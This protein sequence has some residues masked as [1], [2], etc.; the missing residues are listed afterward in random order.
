MLHRLAAYVHSRRSQP[1]PSSTPSALGRT[2][3]QERARSRDPS[4]EARARVRYT[5]GREMEN[6]SERSLMEYC[7]VAYILLSS[8][9]CF[10]DSLGCFPRSLPLG[11]T[12]VTFSD[13]KLDLV[14]SG[15]ERG[16]EGKGF[17]AIAYAAYIIGLLDYCVDADVKLPHPGL[18]VLDS[19]LVTYKRR[20]T[21]PGEAIPD[22]V[23]TAFYVGLANTPATKQVI[24]LENNDPPEQLQAQMQYIHFS[25]SDVGRY[26]FFPPIR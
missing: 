22:D 13:E 26:G 15:K 9:C 11:L 6:S 7:P 21:T 3:A 14:I 8:F 17:R 20:D 23:I 25:R 5:V 24:I 2:G 10:S 12:R 18:V 4:L 19:P 1:A 16:S